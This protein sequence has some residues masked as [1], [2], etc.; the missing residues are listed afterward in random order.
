MHNI[1]VSNLYT[2]SNRYRDSLVYEIISRIQSGELSIYQARKLYNI[3]G[4]M[5]ISRWLSRCGVEAPKIRRS[6]MSKKPKQ[7]KKDDN[8]LLKE[9]L[10]RI[11]Y[12]ETIFGLVKEEY[13]LDCKKILGSGVKKAKE[14]GKINNFV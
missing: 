14:E 3:G 9:A 1:F 12:Y 2:I 13:G 5:T 7:I 6:L 4:K 11:E 10:L 8:I